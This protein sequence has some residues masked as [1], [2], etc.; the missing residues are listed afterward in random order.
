M[1]LCLSIALSFL[2]C[3]SAIADE[4]IRGVVELFTSQG[5]SSCPPADALFEELAQQRGLAVL[6]L[7]VDY[8]DRLGWKDTY[9]SP[10]HS[11]RQRG[12][13]AARGDRAVYTPQAVVNGTRHMNGAD[14][15]EIEDNLDQ[16]RTSLSVP[17][18]LG[19][20]GASLRITIGA[21]PAT[22]AVDTASVVLL[23]YLARREVSI[24]RGEN[25]SRRIAY[26]NIVRGI[27]NIG[28]W[29]GDARKIERP[30]ANLD[31]ADGVFILLQTGTP[32]APGPIIGAAQLPFAK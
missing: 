23:P 19:R 25:A 30:M 9:G 6:S 21:S 32:D 8:W 14:R 4:A 2:T 17:V 24:G 18:S 22:M 12:Y 13:A 10:A 15:G 5:C 3:T 29:D 11:A 20:S 26:T 27:E 16:L 31:T 28:S 1:R 7:P